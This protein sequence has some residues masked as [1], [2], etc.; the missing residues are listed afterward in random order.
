MPRPSIAA[1]LVVFTCTFAFAQPATQ[2]AT[3]P[4]EPPEIHMSGGEA[5]RHDM[6]TA[7]PCPMIIQVPCV[8]D[9]IHGRNSKPY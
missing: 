5:L 1:L 4:A 9:I 3:K 6:E 2:P 8:D 7:P